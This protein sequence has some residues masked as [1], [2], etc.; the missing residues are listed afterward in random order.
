M[1]HSPEEVFGAAQAARVRGDLAAFFRCFDRKDQLRLGTNAMAGLL[2][3]EPRILAAWAAL[4]EKHAIPSAPVEALRSAT[5]ELMRSAQ[6]IY[7]LQGEARAAASS[8]HAALVKGCEQGVRGVLE[9]IADLPAFLGDAEGAF[10]QLHGGGLVSSTLFVGEKLEEVRI[11]G[12]RGWGTRVGT[13]SAGTRWTEDVGFVR[14]RSGEWRIRL[15]A[16]RPRAGR[17]DG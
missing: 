13:S 4:S 5:R 15:L 9:S 14:D 3:E 12:G 17:K 11:E 6:R 1:T 7:S 2:G 16:K 10:R 8:A